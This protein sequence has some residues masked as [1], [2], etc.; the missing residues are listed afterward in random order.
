MSN[1]A[2][3][4]YTFTK[5]IR[6]PNLERL[7]IFDMKF[8][9]P[10]LQGT[11]VRRYK[12][13]LADVILDTG[14]PVTAHCPNTGSMLSCSAPGSRVCLSVSDNPKRKYPLTLEMIEDNSTWIG[15]N[16]AR[17]NS[18]VAE[19][20]EGHRLAEFRHVLEVK[21]EVKTSTHSRLDLLVNHSGMKTYIEVKNCSLAVEGRAMFPDAVTTRGA[22]HLQ[23][24]VR[25][26]GQGCS[27]CIFFLVQRMDVSCFAPAAHIDA[28]YATEFDKARAA[29]VMALA[30]QAQVSPQGIEVVRRLEIVQP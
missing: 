1:V 21:K 17:T 23:E 14:D 29:G 8:P 3:S 15:V 27:G 10:L 28:N 18:I 7:N 13:F 6:N 26:K 2:E 9:T 20:I 16:T 25:L 11:L 30:Y 4:L 12:R 22:K 24:L 5:L 19:A